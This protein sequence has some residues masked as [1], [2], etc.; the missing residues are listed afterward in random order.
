M[1]TYGITGRRTSRGYKK[2]S[3][4]FLDLYVKFK[5]VEMHCLKIAIIFLL[6]RQTV[7]QMILEVIQHPLVTAAGVFDTLRYLVGTSSPLKNICF[8]AKVANTLR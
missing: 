4:C 7:P 8:F 3:N 6:M 2:T 5:L 1:L